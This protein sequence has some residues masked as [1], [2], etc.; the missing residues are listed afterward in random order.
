MTYKYKYLLFDAD[1]TLLDYNQ[2]E[3]YALKEAFK[4]FQVDLQDYQLEKYKIINAQLWAELEKG[5]IS[6]IELRV[7]RFEI[8]FQEL[9]L[10][11][12]AVLFSKKYLEALGQ[13]DFLIEG[14]IELLNSLKEKFELVIITNGIKEVQNSRLQKTKLDKYFNNV[15]ISEEAGVA[16]P[17]R[18]FFDYTMNKIKFFNKKDM[19]IIGD[20][21][22]SD[23]LGGNL[24]SIDT[25]WYNPLGNINTTEI[26]ATYEIEK[27]KELSS[28]VGLLQ[29]K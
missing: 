22:N 4:M 17:D 13:S 7:K 5:T 23:I 10:N 2:S 27:L 24:S 6:S 8:L 9:N 25:C 11:I 16:K 20:S 26:K 14:T 3:T 12:D 19:L 28:V 29:A 1:G 15:I 21:L 18:K